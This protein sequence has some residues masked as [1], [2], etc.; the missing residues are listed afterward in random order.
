M[1]ATITL[2]IVNNQ[3]NCFSLF[4]E[5]IFRHWD[6][7]PFRFFA[8]YEWW[9]SYLDCSWAW[10]T[11]AKSARR[12]YYACHKNKMAATLTVLLLALTLISPLKR[13]LRN[14]W[15]LIYGLLTMAKLAKLFMVVRDTGNVLSRQLAFVMKYSISIKDSTWVILIIIFKDRWFK[16]FEMVPVYTVETVP[17]PPILV[18]TSGVK[19]PSSLGS[20]HDLWL[21]SLLGSG[22]QKLVVRLNRF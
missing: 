1:S 19:K 17:I 15:R 13:R 21:H 11:L 10:K 22:H 9:Q 16:V 5:R 3:I 12:Y 7:E 20:N 6:R 8:F 2:Y 4:H 14:L 18:N